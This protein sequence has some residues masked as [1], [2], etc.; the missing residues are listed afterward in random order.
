MAIRFFLGI[1][2]YGKKATKSPSKQCG[3]GSGTEFKTH[4]RPHEIGPMDW[5]LKHKTC[6]KEGFKLCRLTPTS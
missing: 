5:N 3:Q 2:I 4:K 1:N 6:R